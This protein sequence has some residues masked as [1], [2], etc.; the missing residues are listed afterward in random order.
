MDEAGIELPPYYQFLKQAQET[1]PSI[2]GMGLIEDGGIVK[3]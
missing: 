1:V 3:L 2:T